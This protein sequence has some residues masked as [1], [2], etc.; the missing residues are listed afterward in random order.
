MYIGGNWDFILKV[1][2]VW[3]DP[4]MGLVGNT[5]CPRFC[6]MND[7]GGF[8]L[9]LFSGEAAAPMTRVSPLSPL[10][11]RQPLFTSAS[12]QQTHSLP[13]DDCLPSCLPGVRYGGLDIRARVR[14]LLRSGRQ[15]RAVQ[16]RP[17][18]RERR[19]QHHLRL[20]LHDR[21]GGQGIGHLL[22]ILS[23]NNV[24]RTELWRSYSP[25]CM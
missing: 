5:G 15:L 2:M 13:V 9:Y 4:N 22:T 14:R 10:S 24:N 16:E 1:F 11:C 8:C 7:F 21:Y 18:Q 25:F 23:I 6:P 19:L 12:I 17:R 3:V 20:V